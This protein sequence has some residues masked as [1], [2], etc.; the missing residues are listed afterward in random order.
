MPKIKQRY[1]LKQLAGL[2][3]IFALLPSFTVNGQDGGESLG[4]PRALPVQFRAFSLGMSLDD[5]KNELQKDPLFSFRGDRDVSFLPLKEQN[6]VESGGLNFIKRSFF[7]L[8]DE[9]V[10]IMAFSMNT[11]KTDHYSIYTTF[12][13][14]YGEPRSLN[15]REAVWESDTVRISIERPLTV[16][17]IDK[18]VFDG[19]ISNEQATGKINMELREGFLND[20]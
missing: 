15:P 12:V 16:K 13:K 14:K 6:L 5:L 17:Y 4:A 1:N 18:I 8:K 2:V 9:K 20:F 19:I 10:F 7:Q 3:F 11:E